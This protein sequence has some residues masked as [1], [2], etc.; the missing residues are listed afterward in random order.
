VA[1]STLSKFKL[2]SAILLLAYIACKGDSAVDPSVPTTIT[3]NSATSL[4]GVAGSPVSPAPS[5]VVNDQNG[6]PMAGAI[7]NFIVLS[8]GGTISTASVASN[9]SGIATVASW[10]LGTTAGPNALSASVGSLT[11]VTFT[12]TGTAGAAASLTKSAGDNQS[13]TTG[14]A[15]P[16]APSVVVR[17]ANGNAKENVVV[18]FAVASGGGSVTGA[19]ATSDAAGV[20]TVGS[21]ILGATGTNTLT[22][23]APGVPAVTF[24]A[25]AI[26]NLC[27]VRTTHEFGSSS[28][29]AL[30][31]T[32]CRLSDGTYVDFFSTDLPEA[33]AYLFRQASAFDTYMYL[34]TA[35]GTT[36]GENDDETSDADNTNSAIKALLPPG[37]Y[38]IGASSFDAAITGDYSI[39]SSTTSTSAGQC[40]VVFIVKNVSTSQNIETTDCL[41]GQTPNTSYADVFFIFLKAGQSVT[42]SM[43]STAVDSFLNLVRLDGALVGSNDN[44]DATGSKDA[45][46]VYTAT[47]TNYYAIFTGTKG[48][49]QTG[50]Y[51]LQVQ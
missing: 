40:E 2:T 45:L 6:A 7:V 8:G 3:A 48:Q 38:V 44:K 30:E 14:L 19:T 22:A 4:S 32:D 17:D 51:T 24:T 35:D 47:T 26:S 33:N 12:A 42:I 20:A 27:A 15:A 34:G 28:S 21:W 36:I 31:T 25:S 41:V 10:I 16:V 49:P 23:S 37:T 39:S 50:A 29:G 1:P 13:G 46:L 11:A 18:T 5:I 9:A 43:S